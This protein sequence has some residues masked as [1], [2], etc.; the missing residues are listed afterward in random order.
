MMKAD[1]RSDEYIDTLLKEALSKDN[2]EVS[3][4]VKEKIDARIQIEKQKSN[5]K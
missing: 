1:N 4:R 3:D 2:L 5:K